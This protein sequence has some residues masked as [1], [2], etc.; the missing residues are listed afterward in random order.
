[1]LPS[2]AAGCREKGEVPFGDQLGGGPVHE[3]AVFDALHTSSDSLP[4][5]IRSESVRGDIGATILGNFHGGP[6]FWLGKG[7]DVERA[8]G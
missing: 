7:G 2:R 3:E 5:R 8:E 4:D 1:M 6:Q